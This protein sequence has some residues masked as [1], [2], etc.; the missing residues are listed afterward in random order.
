V[1]GLYLYASAALRATLEAGMD[2]A[3]EARLSAAE[4][5][6]TS[7]LSLVESNRALIRARELGRISELERADVQHTLDELWVRCHVWEVTRAICDH[8]SVVAPT[9]GLRTLDAIH[10]AT[11]LEA[12][13]R[14]GGEIELLTTDDRL[15][16]A[17]TGR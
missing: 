14:L 2:P 7:R 13:R 6:I 16:S 8:A 17:L 3:V 9:T 4:V 1:A 15:K 5:L 10:L 12:R 11:F